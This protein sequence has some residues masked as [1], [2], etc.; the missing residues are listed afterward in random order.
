MAK[1]DKIDKPKKLAYRIKRINIENLKGINNCP[2]SFPSDKPVTAIMGINGSGK[3]TILHAL[4][5]VFKPKEISSKENNRFSDFFTPHNE[6]NWQDSKF[7]VDFRTGEITNQGDKI[8]FN[9]IKNEEEKNIVYGKDKR[10]T[11][12]Y[13]RRL[14]RESIYIGL[15]NLATLADNSGASR[16]SKYDRLDIFDKEQKNRMTSALNKILDAN[17]TDLFECQTTKGNKKFIGMVKNG[18]EYTEHTMGAG[19]KRVFE[20]VKHV[21]SG[22]LKPNGLLIVDEIDVLLHERAFHEL[23]N[24][25]MTESKAM[26]FEVVFTTHRESVIKFKNQINIISIWNIG[27]GIEAYPG[28]SADALRQISNV[29]PDMVNVFV[30]DSLAKTAL[31]ILVESEGINEQVDISLFGSAENSAVILSGLKLTGKRIDTSLAIL[32]GDY[33]ITRDEKVA[34]VN[35]VLSGT[36]KRVE[37][38]EVLSRIFQFN[39][40]ITDV[41]GSPEK[42]HRLWFEGIDEKKVPET[43]K[44]MFENLRKHSRS[45]GALSDYHDYYSELARRSKLENIEYK[46]LTYISKYSDKWEFYISDIK[47]KINNAIAAI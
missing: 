2:I 38:E 14:E 44:T 12:V 8:I 35:R 26:C 46:I 37:K 33:Y 15:Q 16:Y 5:C 1:D 28:V 25:L 30:E 11:P 10:W 36:D 40:D 17:Y 41:K 27:N 21:Y 18:V 24:F 39:L 29:E 34:M 7:S 23:I 22:D 45:I 31:E 42:N 3:S 47:D 20:I 32:D 9:E 4:S 43:D 13:A 19:E 6:N